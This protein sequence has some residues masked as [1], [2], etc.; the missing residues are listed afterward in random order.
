MAFRAY[1]VFRGPL[2][3]GRLRQTVPVGSLLW[4]DDDT[5][6]VRL[7]SGGR[8]FEFNYPEI[9]GVRKAEWIKLDPEQ[10][11]APDPSVGAVAPNPGRAPHRPTVAAPP[12]VVDK[13]AR[14]IRGMTVEVQ[15]QVPVKADRADAGARTAS[16]APVTVSN[17]NGLRITNPK[18]FRGG[19]TL[20]D[21]EDNTIALPPGVSET[22][23]P[24]RT[25]S[26]EGGPVEKI[27]GLEG[28][29]V[30]MPAPF[31]PTLSVKTPEGTREVGVVPP[32]AKVASVAAP[33]RPLPEKAAE[34]PSSTVI[35][36]APGVSW[37]K[38]PHW[39][40]RAK[41]AWALYKDQLEILEAILKIEAEAVVK[42][43]ERIR[44]AAE[45]E[46]VAPKLADPPEASLEEPESP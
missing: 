41:T 46:R 5:E 44:A 1:K 13:E 27:Q 37:D 3:L 19:V 25:T 29:T 2:H 18:E 10:P 33:G 23:A 24:L 15:R 9:R 32:G 45:K 31:K 39:K 8:V 21:Q 34:I 43:I 11:P 28:V 14:T 26:K 36:V 7:E 35:E 40:T 42:E 4:Y 20:S 17:V 30:K 16:E 38:A 6:K 22:G 12:P